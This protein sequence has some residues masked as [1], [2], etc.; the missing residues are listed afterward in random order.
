MKS[1]MYYIVMAYDRAKFL[2]PQKRIKIMSSSS[3]I[4]QTFGS[5][6]Y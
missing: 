3:N 5:A 2:D 6:M 4:H 1:S